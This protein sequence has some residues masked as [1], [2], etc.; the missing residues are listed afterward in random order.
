MTMAAG[1]L[2]VAFLNVC[3]LRRKVNE[4]ENIL[5]SHHIDILGIA[6]TWLESGISDGEVSIPGF[7]LYR[8]DRPTRGGGVAM[9]CHNR[10]L[11]RR[12][13]DLESQDL[14]VLWLEL[15][16]GHTSHL[17]GTAYCPP[18]SPPS[19]WAGFEQNIEKAVEGRQASTLLLGD[20]TVDYSEVSPMSIRLQQ[21]F[22][23]LGLIN[24]VSSPT[25]VT[26]HSS[27]QIDLFFSSV[28]LIGSCQVM[29]LDISDHH[30]LLGRLDIKRPS[31]TRSEV[32]TRSI[33]RIDWTALLLLLLLLLLLFLLGSSNRRQSFYRTP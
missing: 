12:R 3:S 26:Q 23:R 24:Y 20:F 17:M 29:A 6:E 22:S 1:N 30:A 19:Y 4:V 13:L 27:T 5:T 32:Q 31:S 8:K 21:H 2:H 7:R 15:S 18:N 11:T 16:V 10:L 14:E 33:F 9:Y 25:R 28:P